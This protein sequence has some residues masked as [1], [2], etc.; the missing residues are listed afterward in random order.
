MIG[1]EGEGF[2]VAM[3]DLDTA[4]VHTAARAIGLAGGALEDATAYAKQRVQ[5]GRPSRRTRPS[6]SGSPTW[7]PRSP[8]PAA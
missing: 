1:A 5:F 8:R 3:G 7:P 2:K 4:R 6:G